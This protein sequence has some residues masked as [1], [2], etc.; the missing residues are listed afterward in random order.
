MHEEYSRSSP[1]KVLILCHS[2][3]EKKSPFAQFLYLPRPRTRK[4]IQ[5]NLINITFKVFTGTTSSCFYL[6]RSIQDGY[7]LLS[8]VNRSIN[9]LAIYQQSIEFGY[10]MSHLWVLQRWQHWVGQVI[11]EERMLIRAFVPTNLIYNGTWK[12]RSVKL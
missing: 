5:L 3:F 9:K 7:R 10:I 8:C 6:M 2:P 12:Q 1:S 4:W 11:W